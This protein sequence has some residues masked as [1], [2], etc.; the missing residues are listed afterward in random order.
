[1]T[2][3]ITNTSS[4][5]VIVFVGNISHPIVDNIGHSITIMDRSLGCYS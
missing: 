2:A 4:I 5:I 1:L 3:N